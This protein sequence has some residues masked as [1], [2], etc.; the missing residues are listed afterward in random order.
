MK[1][2]MVDFNTMMSTP[3]DKVKLGGEG[4]PFHEEYDRLAPG[5][6]VLLYDDEIAVKAIIEVEMFNGHPYWLGVPEWSTRH[7]TP[8]ELAATVH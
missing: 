4:G 3:V 2:I 6:R 8:P 1:Q 7:Q 5:E